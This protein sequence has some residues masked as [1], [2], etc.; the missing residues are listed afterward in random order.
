MFFHEW[1]E[2]NFRE[3]YQFFKMRTN[4]DLS[5]CNWPLKDFYVYF[6]WNWISLPAGVEATLGWKGLANCPTRGWPPAVAFGKTRR[7][8]PEISK[9]KICENDFLKKKKKYNWFHE[10]NIPPYLKKARI[11]HSEIWDEVKLWRVAKIKQVAHP[12]TS[13]WSWKNALMASAS[14]PLF[15]INNWRKW[16][17]GL[18]KWL[19]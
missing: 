2:F 11:A 3:N 15:S 18:Y 12:W 6:S 1:V 13:P 5:Y 16:S 10:K 17:T 4:Q 8:S 9:I 19:F 14:G 7:G